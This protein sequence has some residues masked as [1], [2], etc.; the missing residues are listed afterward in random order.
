MPV[1]RHADV[2][3][4]ERRPGHRTRNLVDRAQG[5]NGLSMTESVLDPGAAVPLHTHRVEEA[6]VVQRGTGVFQLGD[7]TLTV[8]ADATVLVPPEVVHGFH[9]PGPGQLTILGVFPVADPLT[10]RWTTYLEGTPPPGFTT[11]GTP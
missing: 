1:I 11:G 3:T 10:D 8:D 4:R 9:N 5:A 2:P 6:I 7:A